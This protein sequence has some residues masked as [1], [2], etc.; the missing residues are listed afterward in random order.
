MREHSAPEVGHWYSHRGKGQLFQVVAFDEDSGLIEVQDFEGDV[1]EV[2]LDTWREMPLD[3]AAAPEDWRGPVEVENED[4][5]EY[6]AADGRVRDWRAPVDDIPAAPQD[7][8]D[9]DDEG[10]E[11]S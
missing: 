4:G 5:A 9:V 11:A 8:L 7:L 1:D 3:A 10:D 6:E 2:D